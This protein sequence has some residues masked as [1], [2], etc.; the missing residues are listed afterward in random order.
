MIKGVCQLTARHATTRLPLLLGACLILN[1]FVGLPSGFG[2]QSFKVGI[3]DPQAVIE[4]SEPGKKVLATLK[5]HATVRQTLLASDEE[6]LKKIQDQIKNGKKSETETKKMQG[7]FQQRLEDYQ[8]RAKEFQEEMAR[9]QKEMVLEFMNKIETA[10]KA[11]AERHDFS[12][13]IDKGSANTLKIVLFA[14]QGLDVTDEVVKEVNE[15]FKKK[16]PKG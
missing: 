7:Q 6:E 9:K 12:L 11:V 1:L 13:I 14:A 8:Q 5:E 4:K 15:R 16:T 2:Q 10:T 3:L